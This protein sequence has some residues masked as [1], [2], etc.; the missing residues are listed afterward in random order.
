MHWAANGVSKFTETLKKRSCPF[1]AASL[2]RKFRKV[3]SQ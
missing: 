1:E 2:R 3:I